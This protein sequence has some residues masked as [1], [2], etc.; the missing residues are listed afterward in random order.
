ME[1]ALKKSF[2]EKEED[3]KRKKEEFE[4][5]KQNYGNWLLTQMPPGWELK[6]DEPEEVKQD[7]NVRGRKGSEVAH[8]QQ[9]TQN[10]PGASEGLK[11]PDRVRKLIN[12]FQR[13]Q[14]VM[15]WDE[16]DLGVVTFEEKKIMEE[17]ATTGCL[18]CLPL[19]KK[20]D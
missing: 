16:G 9:L 4:T 5:A 11:V 13:L 6:S 18:P 17:P 10:F 12:T 1:K 19:K 20:K 8:S 14:S 3:L 15:N 2:M 7:A